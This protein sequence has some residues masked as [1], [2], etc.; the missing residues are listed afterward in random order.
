MI[1]RD[2]FGRRGPRILVILSDV[3]L[4]FVIISEESLYCFEWGR[5]DPRKSV[6]I[7]ECSIKRS[8]IKLTVVL[9]TSLDDEHPY[10]K[11]ED[12]RTR[13]YN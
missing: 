5:P 2:K 3:I 6:T 4:Q 7:R 10:N 11:F 12:F 1:L 9:E 13:V 8:D